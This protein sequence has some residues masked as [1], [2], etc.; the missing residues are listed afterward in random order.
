MNVAV[1]ED[2]NTILVVTWTQAMAADETWLEFSFE[3]GK[4]MKSRPKPGAAG[5][6]DDVVLG[7]PG[8]TAGDDP[9]RQRAGGVEYK[10]ARL[11]GH[12]RRGPERHA[13]AEVLAYDAERASPERW[14]VRRGRGLRRRLQ[15]PVLLLPHDFWL[16]IMDRQ[17]RIVWYY[18]DPASNATSSFQRI[19]RDGEY[20]WI[21]KRPFGGRGQRACSR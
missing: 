11:H 10:S 9:R 7:V 5:A 18:A 17:G 21:E 4:V 14:H 19:A 6:H 8:D 15:Q 2:V 3:D 12:D 20:I 16:Y 1:H 13:G